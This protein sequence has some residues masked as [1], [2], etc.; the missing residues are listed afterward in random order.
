[1]KALLNIDYT[2]D[3]VDTDGL[4]TCGK[5]GQDIEQ[6]ITTITNE[7]ITNNDYVVFAVDLHKEKECTPPLNLHFFLLITSKGQKDESSTG[8]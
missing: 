1:M 5:P 4:L 3:F 8:Y 7:F 2:F 6:K